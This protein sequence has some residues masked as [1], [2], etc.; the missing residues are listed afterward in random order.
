[1]KAENKRPMRLGVAGAG[2]IVSEFLPKLAVMDGFSLTAIYNRTVKKAEHLAHAYGV[3]RVCADYDE[4]LDSGID[5]V[6]IAL[7]NEQ[8]ASFAERALIQGINVIVEKPVTS[9]FTEAQ[10]LADLAKEKN[11]FLFEAVSSPHIDSFGVIDRW[12]PEIGELKLAQSSFTQ[13]SRRYDRFYA[14]ELPA[15]FDPARSGGALMD[16][17]VYNLSLFVGLFGEPESL[18]YH[19]NIERG[20]DVGGVLCMRYPGFQAFSIAAKD[21]SDLRGALFLGTRGRIVAKGHPGRLEQ[22]TMTLNDGTERSFEDSSFTDGLPHFSA[23]L[24][25]WQKQDKEFFGRHLE[26]SLTVSRLMTEARLSVGVRFPADKAAN[27]A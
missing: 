15:V 23:L 4:L 7:T 12:L 9:N 22:V 27:H 13:Y 6:Y 3:E 26:S 1:M 17:G 19:A 20:I 14:G 24:Q 21:C 11:C 2:T 18:A 5:A 10:R 8:H 16:L 25:A